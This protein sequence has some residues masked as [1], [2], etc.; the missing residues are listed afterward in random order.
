MATTPS[1]RLYRR[2]GKQCGHTSRQPDGV[3]A[4]RRVGKRVA[5]I[6]K[7]LF[8]PNAP[9]A[10]RHAYPSSWAHC[11]H[12][13]GVGTERNG[14]P[15]ELFGRKGRAYRGNKS[16]GARGGRTQGYG[17]C[18]GSR[19]Y[20]KR[21]DGRLEPRRTEKNR[22]HETLWK[23]RRGGRTGGFSRFGRGCVHHGRDY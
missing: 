19:I 22:T 23:G 11:K 1:R 10:E 5:D 6:A 4:E 20:R 18:R 2:V 9:T 17:E 14:R 13:F 12:L 15:S 8:L 16:L 7:R 3:Y 21:H